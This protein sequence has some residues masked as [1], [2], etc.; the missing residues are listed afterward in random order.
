MSGLGLLFFQLAA[1]QTGAPPPDIE[2]TARVQ[3]REVT[4]RQ[5]GEARIELHAEPGV[6][7]PV[8]V[9]R[10]APPGARSYRNLTIDLHGQARL[11][12]PDQDQSR[13]GN[14]DGTRQP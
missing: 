7:P 11:S 4:I 9:E 6:A 5:D 13:Q 3:A 8:R 2:V 10:S 1:A 14:N 12:A